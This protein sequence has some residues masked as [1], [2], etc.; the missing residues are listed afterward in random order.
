[1]KSTGSS[2]DWKVNTSYPDTMLGDLERIVKVE[3][4]E[5]AG[6]AA[7]PL[8]TTP[9]LSSASPNFHDDASHPRTG[10]GDLE[11]IVISESVGDPSRADPNS[12]VLPAIIRTT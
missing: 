3:I 2:L 6:E 11:S 5:S 4:S 9:G 12:S 10:L 1:M 8:G 7:R